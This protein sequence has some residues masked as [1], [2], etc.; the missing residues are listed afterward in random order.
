[1]SKLGFPLFLRPEAKLQSAKRLL[2]NGKI[3]QGLRQLHTLATSG[4][5]E[6]QFALGE[7]Y[8]A[9]K[10]VPI[11]PGEALRWFQKA[12]EY[13]HAQA[14]QKL[15]HLCYM[16]LGPASVDRSTVFERIP[17]Q[18]APDYEGALRWAEKAVDGGDPDGM[19]MMAHLLMQGPDSLRD[20]ERGRELYRRAAE[21]GNVQG[22]YGYG[23]DLLGSAQN[24]AGRERGL[25]Y[26]RKAAQGG[27]ADAE[28][29]LGTVLEYEGGKDAQAFDHFMKAAE[30][31]RPAA[32]MKV[33]VAYYQG[34]GVERDV[35]KAETWLRK[36]AQ[37]GEVEAIALVGDINLQG[38]GVTPNFPEAHSWYRKAVQSGHA[39][40]AVTLAQLI[41]NGMGCVADSAEA[42]RLLELAASRGNAAA[43]EL[44]QR[45]G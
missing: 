9:D 31:G 5:A 41:Y 20:S 36:A 6:A 29:T 45:L 1:M 21:A 15:A 2:E 23:L 4:N 39:G 3:R 10:D 17:E 33:G 42:K 28:L 18:G 27:L 14:C 38:D 8:L 22:L 16:G 30:E 35:S 44:L 24:A 12:A 25:S 7:L 34:R 37:G 11:N 43:K 32:Q 40:A 13:G 26:I 19:A